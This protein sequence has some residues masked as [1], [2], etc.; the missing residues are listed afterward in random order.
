MIAARGWHSTAVT[1]TLLLA[2][3][4][5]SDCGFD[6][7]GQTEIQSPT[8][9]EIGHD[10]SGDCAPLVVPGVR[11]PRVP[12]Y[13]LAGI[14][15]EKE[16]AWTALEF[17]YGPNAKSDGDGVMLWAAKTEDDELDTTLLN[18][19]TIEVVQG[20]R[21]GV[22]GVNDDRSTT[23]ADLAVDH[24]FYQ[25][26]VLRSPDDMATDIEQLRDQFVAAILVSP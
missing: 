18:Y 23:G 8:C 7:N 17:T 15:T 26:Q 25:L 10:L 12:G 19:A 14:R 24:V 21:V 11:I 6:R 9:N 20:V 4:V 5:L 22:T 2:A 16:D 3:V 1:A 13:R